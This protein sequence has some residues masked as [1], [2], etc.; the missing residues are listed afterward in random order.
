MLAEVAFRSHPG[1]WSLFPGG[2]EAATEVDADWALDVVERVE[3]VVAPDASAT[4]TTGSVC[5]HFTLAEGYDL[6]SVTRDCLLVLW[7]RPRRQPRTRLYH[8]HGAPA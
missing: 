2:V 1:T 8:Q 4:L 7:D 6:P 3:G 5:L